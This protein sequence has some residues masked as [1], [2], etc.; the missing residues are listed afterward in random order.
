MIR[1]QYKDRQYN[2]GESI[3][4]CL[5]FLRREA[6]AEGHEDLSLI[7]QTAVS[8]A[9]SDTI[10]FGRAQNGAPKSEPL[11]EFLFAFLQ[12]NKE[13]QQSVL[14]IIDDHLQEN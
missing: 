12:S 5:E 9:S 11:I 14:E 13:V 1:Q 7:L 4:Y 3:L 8:L 6:E 2:N 10:R